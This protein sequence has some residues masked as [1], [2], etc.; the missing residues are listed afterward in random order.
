M[1][2]R[3]VSYSAHPEP[4]TPSGGKGTGS[5]PRIFG[6]AE[7]TRRDTGS[8]DPGPARQEAGSSDRRAATGSKG[9]SAPD[10][11]GRTGFRPGS[12]EPDGTQ[13]L[14]PYGPSGGTGGFGPRILSTAKSG[15]S[16]FE[17]AR[18]MEE[19]RE[20]RHRRAANRQ[21]FGPVGEPPGTPG[22]FR[23]RRT[24]EDAGPG[25]VLVTAPRKSPSRKACFGGT[26][27]EGTVG[28]GSN[29]GPHYCLDLSPSRRCAAS[30]N[31]RGDAEARRVRAPDRDQRLSLRASARTESG[32]P[33]SPK[34]PGPRGGGLRHPDRRHVHAFSHGRMNIDRVVAATEARWGPS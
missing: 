12:C 30:P 32:R 9:A 1:R 20:F 10:V 23:P 29:A 4:S 25:P 18:G 17:D 28:P 13:G 31:S 16:A 11:S 26:G 19:E 8:S 27:R 33:A 3:Q 24:P 34:F 22:G 5:G 14:R 6:S 21:G 7:R 15:A 2:E